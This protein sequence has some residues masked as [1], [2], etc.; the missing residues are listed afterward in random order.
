VSLGRRIEELI[1]DRG[2]KPGD[3]LASERVLAAELGVSR[4]HLREVIQ[5]LISRGIITSRQ[6]GGTFVANRTGLQSL[7]EA[8]KP[9]VPLVQGDAGYWHDVMELRK[10][11]DT[12]AAYYAALRANDTDKTN[13][14]R[15]FEAMATV[16]ADDPVLQARADAQFHI[17]IA[18][19]S[20]NI[21]LCQVVSGLSE[22]LAQSITESLKRFYRQSGFADELSQQ[23][24]AI[25]EAILAG[26]PDKARHAMVLHLAFV[27]DKLRIIEDGRAREQ[28][29]AEALK[30]PEF[31]GKV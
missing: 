18:Q 23:H 26:E 28:R 25:L 10:S 27:E 22:L 7:Q 13:L 15:S 20:H 21:V 14:V 1:A 11:L 2:L 19:A 9:L 17:A 3:R 5:Q 29:S 12:D 31:K 6:G 8:L 4:S 16:D 24:S 30:R